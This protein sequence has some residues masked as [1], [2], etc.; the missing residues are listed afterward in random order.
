MYLSWGTIKE[1]LLTGASDGSMG[2]TTRWGRKLRLRSKTVQEGQ[3]IMG[4]GNLRQW[5]RSAGGIW[6][7]PRSDRGGGGRVALRGELLER[8]MGG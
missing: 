4:A 3:K 2:E 7:P 8:G 1:E 5:Q 6:N